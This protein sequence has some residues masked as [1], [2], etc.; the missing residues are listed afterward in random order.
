MISSIKTIV[1]QIGL[2]GTAASLLETVRRA[3]SRTCRALT[4]SDQKLIKRHFQQSGP[5]RLHLGCGSHRLT[6]WLNTDYHPRTFEVMHL[7]AVGRYP[8]L[9]GVFDLAY[10]EHMIEHVPYSAGAAMISECFRVLKPG[11]R[12]RLVTPDLAFLIDLV[13]PQPSPIQQEYLSWSTQRFIPWAP[14]VAPAFVINSFVRNWGHQF[15]YDEAA[16]RTALE[17]AGFARVVRA[18]LN[19]SEDVHLR[20]LEFETRMPPGF[21]RLESLILE[22]VKPL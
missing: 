15:I 17:R 14:Q 9:D 7:N 19:S 10:S 6:G 8:F 3:A 22:A 13:R 12:I 20:N 2:K 11:G 4:R 21:L 1:E 5:K 16:L 18:E